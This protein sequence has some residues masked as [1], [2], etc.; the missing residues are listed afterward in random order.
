MKSRQA[1]RVGKINKAFRQDVNFVHPKSVTATS[2][3][4]HVSG[5]RLPN[6]LVQPLPGQ[7][8]PRLSLINGLLAAATYRGF[9]SL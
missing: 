6:A 4:G 9:S 1:C 2:K 8:L 7:P 3:R 5:E